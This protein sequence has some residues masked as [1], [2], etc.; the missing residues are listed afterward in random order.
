MWKEYEHVPTFVL[1]LSKFSK[2]AIAATPMSSSA[3]YEEE[4]ARGNIFG[5]SASPPP[6]DLHARTQNLGTRPREP[7]YP[8]YK[9][10]VSSLVFRF[11][12]FLVQQ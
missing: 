8:P 5:P 9:K 6:H 12:S 3:A 4:E 11:S 7:A 10:T 2:P 1:E